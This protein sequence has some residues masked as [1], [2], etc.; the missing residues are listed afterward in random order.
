MKYIRHL[1]LKHEVSKLIHFIP[2]S[3]YTP[4]FRQGKT[5]EDSLRLREAV[6]V[7]D[8]VEATLVVA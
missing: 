7:Y 6:R 5:T 1:V 2:R 3:H 4:W 8:F